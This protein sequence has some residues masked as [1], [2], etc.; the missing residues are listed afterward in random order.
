MGW[1]R[2]STRIA[3]FAVG[4]LCSQI[5]F[6]A[7][8]TKSDVPKA[9]PKLGQTNDIT[10]PGCNR[11]FTLNGATQ[12]VDSQRCDGE[13]LRPHLLDVPGA[14]NLLD[15]YQETRDIRFSGYVG[16]IAVLSLISSF[17]ISRLAYEGEKEQVI[18]R[19]IGIATAAT[20]G[21][22]AFGYGFYVLISNEGRLR[23]A[24]DLHNQQKPDHP[25]TLELGVSFG[26]D[27]ESGSAHEAPR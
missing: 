27:L 3:I 4:L 23:D 12:R 15:E 14:I 8:Q 5:S 17:W 9:P 22:I 6:S 18:V 2:T 25:I 24:V 16:S 1:L 19:N 26:F 11:T 13:H 20:L 10:P 21:A 7:P